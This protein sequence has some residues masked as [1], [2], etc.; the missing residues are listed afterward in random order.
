[1]GGYLQLEGERLGEGGI[2]WYGVG[3]V[4]GCDGDGLCGIAIAWCSIF[5]VV[6]R[7]NHMFRSAK[8]IS[9]VSRSSYTS[10]LTGGACIGSSWMYLPSPLFVSSVLDKPFDILP[11]NSANYYQ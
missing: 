11:Y 8:C 1:M 6:H 2:E 9:P 7:G 3:F 10:H 4:G 5:S